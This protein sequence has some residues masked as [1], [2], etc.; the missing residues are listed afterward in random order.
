MELL[1]EQPATVTELV[2][3]VPISQPAVSQHLRVL[4]ESGLV[5]VEPEGASRIYSIDQ[6]GLIPVRAY[7]ESFWGDALDAFA[8][9]AKEMAKS[10]P[11]AE[12]R[13]PRRNG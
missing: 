12:L 9:A 7:I 1:R 8:A 5:R 10:L 6:A 13:K 3:R 4:R 11:T 2:R